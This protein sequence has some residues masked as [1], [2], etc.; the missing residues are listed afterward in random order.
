MFGKTE[1]EGPDDTILGPSQMI[2]CHTPLREYVPKYGDKFVLVSGNGDVMNVCKEYGL[3]KA[4][5]VEELFAL[6]P[7]LSPISMK[8]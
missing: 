7:A 6:I 1:P 2:C 8:E 3:R 4:I 5:H